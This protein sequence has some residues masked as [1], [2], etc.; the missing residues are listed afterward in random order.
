MEVERL[1]K[2]SPLMTG[3]T[4]KCIEGGRM[5]VKNGI[6][7][8]PELPPSAFVAFNLQK[9]DLPTIFVC[10]LLHV[11]S[12]VESEQK[13]RVND[14]I[15]KM[16]VRAKIVKTIQSMVCL[17]YFRYLDHSKNICPPFISEKH[18]VLL[19]R[20]AHTAMGSTSG[21]SKKMVQ[22]GISGHS[23]RRDYLKANHFIW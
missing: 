9:N 1:S 23:A 20:K 2:W 12:S 10:Y 8:R 6:I 4:F 7:W 11:R 14:M 3:A 19:F 18:G 21:E 15:I 5:P 16:K 13:M 22:C 17:S